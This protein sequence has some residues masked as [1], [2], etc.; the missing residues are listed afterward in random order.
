MRLKQRQKQ[1]DFG[2]NTRGYDTYIT[3]VPKYGIAV[4]ESC[5][6]LPTCGIGALRSALVPSAAAL[7]MLIDLRCGRLCA[8]PSAKLPTLSRRT[9]RWDVRRERLTDRFACRCATE[10]ADR[11]ETV[12]RSSAYAPLRPDPTRPKDEGGNAVPHVG[13]CARFTSPRLRV[14]ALRRVQFSSFATSGRRCRLRSGGGLSMRTIR[15]TWT[16]LKAAR[17]RRTTKCAAPRASPTV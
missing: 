1:I 6:L 15:P 2:K 12:G 9:R 16:M 7:P 14:G 13:I 5:T 4:R 17:A 8:G 3:R 10:G 11:S